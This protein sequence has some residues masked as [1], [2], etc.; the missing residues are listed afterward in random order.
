MKER[1]PMTVDLTDMV[2]VITGAAGIIGSAMSKD[3]ARNGAKVV[4]ADRTQESL[5]NINREVHEAGGEMTVVKADVSREEDC[6]NLIGAAIKKYG[7]VDVLINN[8]GINDSGGRKKIFEFADEPWHNTIECNLDGAFYLSRRASREMIKQGEGGSILN[9]SSV[10]GI[11]PAANQCAFAAAKAGLINLTRAMAIELGPY[12]IRVNCLCPG[13]T[14]WKGSG[15]FREGM[16][17]ENFALH[18]KHLPLRRI[19]I[20]EEMSGLA[21]FL[22]SN[23]ASYITGANHV[24]DGGWTC[25]IPRGFEF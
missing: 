11:V 19:G 15:K 3:F 23:E 12:N 18:M 7:R 6:E 24:V 9:I 5:D 16:G 1:K 22:A 17:E 4:G 25:N 10:M 14:E 2:V 21:C 8:A 20:G 13:N